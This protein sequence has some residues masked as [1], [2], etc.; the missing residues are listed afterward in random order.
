MRIRTT[1]N[2]NN[3]VPNKSNKKTVDNKEYKKIIDSLN[4]KRK[5]PFIWY[6]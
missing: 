4:I 2:N 6:R 5:S 1:T 3:F